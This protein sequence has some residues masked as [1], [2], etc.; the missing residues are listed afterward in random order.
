MRKTTRERTGHATTPHQKESAFQLMMLILNHITPNFTIQAA[1]ENA[2]GLFRW[3]GYPQA[4]NM[5]RTK[6]CITRIQI[7]SVQHVSKSKPAGFDTLVRAF[8]GG[9]GVCGRFRG[10]LRWFPVVLGWIGG[11]LGAVWE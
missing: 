1:P 6:K 3:S 2:E 11:V 9:H 4:K 5:G 7:K 10:V 8:W